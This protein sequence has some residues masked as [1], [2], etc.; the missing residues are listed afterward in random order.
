M[1]LELLRRQPAAFADIVG[2]EIPAGDTGLELPNP[3]PED[4]NVPEWCKCGHCVAVNTQEEKN[5]AQDQG[6][7]ASQLQRCFLKL[8]WMEYF[9]YCNEV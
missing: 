4:E 3:P 6:E 2:G 5:A 7:H 8:Y 1:A 9:G